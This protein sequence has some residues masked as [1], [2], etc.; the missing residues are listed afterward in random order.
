MG[1]RIGKVLAS[2][3]IPELRRDD[4]PTLA[5]DAS[6]NAQ[7]NRYGRL[8]G[9]PTASWPVARPAVRRIGASA[10][11]PG[12]RD[13]SGSPHRGE[14]RDLSCTHANA[15]VNWRQRVLGPNFQ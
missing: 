2:R 13:A 8:R 3:I 12:A 10:M 4:E 15:E 7:I 11:A 1:R 5:H 9:Q 14:M 6:T